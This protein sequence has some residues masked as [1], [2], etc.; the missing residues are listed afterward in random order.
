MRQTEVVAATK[1]LIQGF[2]RLPAKTTHTLSAGYR[3]ANFE[4]SR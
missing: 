1:A 3:A 4:R 2:D